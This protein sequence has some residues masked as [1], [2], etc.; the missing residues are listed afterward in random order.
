MKKIAFSAL[1]AALVLSACTQ[2]PPT[3][4]E[5]ANVA[6]TAAFTVTP[7][8]GVAPLT[9]SMDASSSTDSDGLIVD[10][11]WSFGDG[12][13]GTGVGIEHEFLQAGEYEIEL[14][15]TDN[16]GTTD[17]ITH[18]IT[19][20]DAPEPVV[21]DSFAA[22]DS[23]PAPV[24]QVWGPAFTQ[25]FCFTPTVD[26]VLS[27][28]RWWRP[29]NPEWVDRPLATISSANVY[30]SL[31][32]GG[33]E[34]FASSSFPI[35]VV[36]DAGEWITATFTEPVPL[37]AGV[38]VCTYVAV[39]ADSGMTVSRDYGHFNGE[40]SRLGLMN[41]AVPSGRFSSVSASEAAPWSSV[42]AWYWIDPVISAVQP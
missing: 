16:D 14:T 12:E 10:D 5:P 24:I 19:V 34:P 4:P 1:F 41:A 28:V 2:S 23:T 29:D 35:G 7:E 9:V 17:S 13:T 31:D 21:Y 22:P 40:A 33:A 27:D 39:T 11:A 8:I 30:V 26:V 18:S 32:A 25:G 15:V 42:N 37:S 36:A 38:S 3:N 6:P 20:G